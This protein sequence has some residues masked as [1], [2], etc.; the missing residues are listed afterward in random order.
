MRYINFPL[1][2]GLALTS[3]LGGCVGHKETIRYDSAPALA[4]SNPTLPT[5]MSTHGQDAINETVMTS[6]RISTRD[7]GVTPNG[8]AITEFT[9][10]NTS[11][12]E[13]KVINFGGIITQIRV[14]DRNGHVGDV[15]LGFDELE[16]YLERSPF[17]GALIGRVGNRIAKGKFTIDGTT[18]QVAA[19]SGGNNL[20]G[21]PEGFDKRVW[22]AEVIQKD[23]DD[24]LRLSL[25]SPDG[26]QG[27]PGNLQVE[28]IYQFTAKNE[29]VV[30][31]R[32]TTDKPT[33]VN[34]T[35]HSYFNLA[36]QGDIL[37]HVLHVNAD[38]IN[39]VD[40]TMIPAGEPMPVAGTPFDFRVAKP[41]GQDINVPHEQLIRG[42]GYDHN[43]LINQ[44][45]YKALT[46][47]A[48]VSE[49]TTGRTL[50]VFTQEPGVQLYTGNFLGGGLKSRGQEYTARTG[51]CIE[52]QHAPDSIN[53]P[54]FP[55]IVLR[56]GEEYATRTVFAFG[57]E[58]LGGQ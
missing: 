16:P 1:I 43:F 25:L 44:P 7:F 41:I 12:S 39:A 42:G 48:R 9:F 13:M 36:G 8:D 18:Y 30:D 55:S 38:H 11:G 54:Q 27:F 23:G 17:I 21:G 6:T 26:D 47:A 2:A 34:L 32:A 45:T 14:P 50:T 22:S 53:Q 24:A 49:P 40:D 35:Q 10:T 31:Y 58:S 5:A 52:P 33:P 37:S 28:V 29:V 4:E 19:N 56:P 57:V 20:H 46:L 3:V 15:A 51:F